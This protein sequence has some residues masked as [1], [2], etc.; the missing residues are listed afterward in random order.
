MRTMTVPVNPEAG[1][2]RRAAG[3]LLVCVNTLYF[4]TYFQRV[5]IPG[6]VFNQLQTSFQTSAGGVALLASLFLYLYGVMQWPAGLLADRFGAVRTILAGGGVLTLGALLFPFAQCLTMLYAARVLVGLG[7]SLMFICLIKFL[8]SF[9]AAGH[10]AVLLGISLSVGYAGGLVGTLPFDLAVHVWGWRQS[11]A[12]VAL[13]C[14]L[15]LAATALLYRRLRRHDPLPVRTG[16]KT[17]GGLWPVNPRILPLFFVH[18]TNFSVYFLFQ[19]VIGKKMVLDHFRLRESTGALFTFCMMLTT[20]IC[21]FSSGFLSRA[22]GNRRVPLLVFSTAAMLAGGAIVMW[23]L[24]AGGSF[25]FVLLGYCLLAMASLGSPMGNT[26]MKEM[27]PP[28]NVGAAVGF[29]NSASY[30]SVAL[31]TSLAGWV[32]DRFSDQALVTDTAVIYP[33]RAYSMVIGGC[34]ALL[35]LAL[36]AG[37]FLHETK[38]RGV[39]G[40]RL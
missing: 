31:Y 27:H 17:A 30:L 29:I 1:V 2:T 34:L 37:F 18:S 4:F 35:F 20:V 12:A 5:A 25:V 15:A 9:F 19:T 3:W 7:S 40:A 8:V 6:T 13:I 10:F 22:L 23:T 32:M 36:I 16:K 26:L 24:H 21:L 38:G 28:E 14:G 11:L 39:T 33:A